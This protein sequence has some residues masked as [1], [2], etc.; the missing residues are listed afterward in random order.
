M[1]K[2]QFGARPSVLIN[3]TNEQI[4]V[5]MAFRKRRNYQRKRAT[6]RRTARRTYGRYRRYAN[7]KRPQR[8]SRY[9]RRAAGPARRPA[10]HYNTD[11][12]DPMLSFDLLNLNFGGTPG[13]RK[14]SWNSL[15]LFDS[16]PTGVANDQR[17]GRQCYV[18]GF[19]FHLHFRTQIPD[20]ASEWQNGNFHFALLQANDTSVNS[21]NQKPSFSCPIGVRANDLSNFVYYDSGNLSRSDIALGKLKNSEWRIIT[22]RKYFIGKKS[23]DQNTLREYETEFYIP[24]K[25]NVQFINT[26]DR[27]GTKPFYILCWYVPTN[28]HKEVS[29]RTVNSWC[30]YVT[31]FKPQL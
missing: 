6:R 31:Y 3:F 5:T 27:Q 13:D 8:V 25:K 29:S 7:R 11:L 22:H 12:L 2:L 28:N 30:R 21:I 16:T 1:D 26:T 19:R 15:F 24:I 10:R 17:L 18:H 23:A 20:T 4:Y 9:A 14:Y